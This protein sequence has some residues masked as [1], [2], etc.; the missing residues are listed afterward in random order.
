M[1]NV[2]DLFDLV[3]RKKQLLKLNQLLETLDLRQPVEGYVKHSGISSWFWK[4]HV[5]LV[6]LLNRILTV[7]SRD[8]LSF[9]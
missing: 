1:R 5:S 4:V 6:I 8:D 7:G 9:R 2:F 3:R